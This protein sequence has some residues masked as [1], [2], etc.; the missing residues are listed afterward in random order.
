MFPVLFNSL[1]TPSL[2]K[3]PCLA[4]PINFQPPGISCGDVGTTCNIFLYAL[5]Y[6]ENVSTL[7][8]GLILYKMSCMCLEN[9]TTLESFLDIAHNVL[10]RQ[11]DALIM[12]FLFKLTQLGCLGTILKMY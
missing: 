7:E 4:K 2:T 8:I 6:F 12:Y 9:G 1:L 5:K 10:I 3:F 11:S